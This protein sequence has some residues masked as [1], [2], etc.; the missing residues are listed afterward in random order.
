M[1]VAVLRAATTEQTGR[2]WATHV[3]ETAML[4]AP[5]ALALLAEMAMGLISTVM[6]G[7][8]GA[9]ALAAGGLA[10]NVFF[11]CLIILQG[12]LSG[13][14]VLAAHAIGARRDA[15]VPLVYWSGVALACAMAL[16][17]F[18]LLSAP[19]TLL[20]GL[21]EPEPLASDMASYLSI[22]RWA[23]PAGLVGV[24][25]MRQFL[26]A[27]G[28]QRVLIWVMPGGVCLHAAANQL[29]IRG[30]FGWPGL[31]FRGSAA[32]TVV[33]LTG[34]A[35]VLLGILHSRRKF[36]AHVAPA[37]PR[38][39]VIVSL[40]AIGLPAGATVA[41]ETA[42]FFAAGVFAGR[43]GPE[44]LAAHMIAL[45]VASTTFMVPLALSQAANVRVALAAGA[46]QMLAARRA[47]L[48]AIGLGAGFMVG[49]ALVLGFAPGLIVG[50]YLPGTPADAATASL[51]ARLLRIAGVFQ[52]ADGTQASAS[53]ALRG[54]KDT[55][56]PMVLAAL[57][58][59]GVGFWAGWFL[60]FHEAL[61]VAGLWW[62][63]FSGLACTAIG[64]TTRFL[65][66]S[67][68]TARQAART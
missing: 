68:S 53:G 65:L 46:G 7:G 29:L 34:V 61:G 67:A 2:A 8:L 26:P 16:P 38:A 17:V 37:W 28:L 36:A 60:A 43:L 31:G 5:I 24:G 51:A 49:A 40:L 12:V 22:L 18:L 55:R 14:G 13:A 56:V 66:K 27:V 39:A 21:G 58:Y 25:I 44:A 20:R 50:I 1:T 9:P 10:T 32:A 15:E 33:S 62:G 63:L 59:W 52:V 45:S 6:L 30:A 64:L 35:L 42:L 19:L 3:R 4:A 41:V 23:V 54:L 47:G 57:G 11:T 48:T